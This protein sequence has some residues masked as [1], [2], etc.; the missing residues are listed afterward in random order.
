M[1]LQ[2]FE[3]SVAAISSKLLYPSDLTVSVHKDPHLHA[4]VS[5]EIQN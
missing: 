1:V 3:E 5:H 2:V 4:E